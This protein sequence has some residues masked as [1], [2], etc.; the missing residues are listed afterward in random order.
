MLYK[1]YSL[2][3]ASA[4]VVLGIVGYVAGMVW[5][6]YHMQQKKKSLPVSF[7][8]FFS[9][10]GEAD[11]VKC[12]QE[13]CAKRTD[14][15]F[16][17][18]EDNHHWSVKSVDGIKYGLINL[19]QR[20]LQYPHEEWPQVIVHHFEIMEAI[21]VKSAQRDKEAQV[22]EQVA[23]RLMIRLERTSTIHPELKLLGRTALDDLV[24]YIVVD[25]P[26]NIHSLAA[27]FLQVWN[28]SLS[29][30]FEKAMT[31]TKR[32]A[33]FPFKK[34]EVEGAPVY[35]V[36]NDSFYTATH[37]RFLERYPESMAKGGRIFAMPNRHT[38]IYIPMDDTDSIAAFNRVIHTIHQ[39]YLNGPGSITSTAYWENPEGN[40]LPIPSMV[41]RDKQGSV[42]KLNIFPPDEFWDWISA[43][44]DRKRSATMP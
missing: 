34:E 42:D 5:W 20:C 23:D 30:V 41:G 26:E 36:V 1:G 25:Y 16:M 12:M 18:L 22:Y 9:E 40:I 8:T 4:L 6:K 31:N 14:R 28:K 24:E 19:A 38:L 2:N 3:T 17:L 33:P 27:N 7:R 37:W 29:E 21:T 13:Y 44:P 15:G 39:R 32:E 11:F 10:K 43:L 35:T